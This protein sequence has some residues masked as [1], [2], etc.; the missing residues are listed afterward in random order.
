MPSTIKWGSKPNLNDLENLFLA[1][2]VVGNAKDIQVVVPTTKLSRKFVNDRRSAYSG[3]FIC[4]DT[5]S[6]AGATDQNA[7]IRFTGTDESGDFQGDI[8]VIRRLL[9][10]N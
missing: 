6:N 4:R 2:H 3:K 8:R 1:Q 10:I 5:H 9:S 7:A